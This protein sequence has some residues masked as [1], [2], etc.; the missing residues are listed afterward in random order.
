MPFK[1][2]LRFVADPVHL[3][4]KKLKIWWSLEIFFPKSLCE[5]MMTRISVISS[6]E[7][8]S[9]KCSVKPKTIIRSMMSKLTKTA[10]ERC[11][12]WLTVLYL[13]NKTS[14]PLIQKTCQPSPMNLTCF[15]RKLFKRQQK[16]RKAW[17]KRTTY[18]LGSGYRTPI[19]ALTLFNDQWIN[20]LVQIK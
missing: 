3:S 7:T 6:L 14:S 4:T 11:G 5:H 15:S 17:W 8:G 20:L 1:N 12:K 9:R 19:Q 16:H 13:P 18:E 10:L 2:K